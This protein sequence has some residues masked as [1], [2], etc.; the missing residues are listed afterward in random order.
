MTDE[1]PPIAEDPD[2]PLTAEDVARVDAEGDEPQ[3]DTPEGDV[4]PPEPAQPASDMIAEDTFR[5]LEAAAKAHRTKVA[6]IL[7][8]ESYG[9]IECP[10]CIASIVP[11]MVN[12]ADAGNLHPEHE[13]IV[14]HYL[15]IS[16][17]MEYAQDDQVSE[18]PVCHGEGKTKTG[19]KVPQFA[20]HDCSE[21][22][23]FGYVPPPTIGAR[24]DENGATHELTPADFAPPTEHADVDNWGEPRIL[25]DGRENPNY[26]RQPQF[27]IPV[28]PWGVTAHLTAQDIPA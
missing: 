2:A 26:G 21:C 18:C 7:G 11:G 25:P 8:D 19:S 15:G 22:R 9:L 23:G 4:P 12:L 27:K 10:L 5:K 24:P 28:P 17:E 3:G 20:T 1:A 14:K 16:R 13:A 6:N